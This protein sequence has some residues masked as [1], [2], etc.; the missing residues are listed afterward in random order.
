MGVPAMIEEPAAGKVAPVPIPVTV[1]A[2]F[3]GAGKTTLVNHIL[4]GNHGQR[5]AVVVN[6]FGSINID[7]EL[8]TNL[9]Q[10]MVSLANGCICCVIRSDLI[11][12]VLTLAG[13]ADRPEH[14]IIESSGV[15]NP[16]S[17]ERAF[18]LPEIWHT[19]QYAGTVSVVD[20]DQVL[21]LTDEQALNGCMPVNQRM[22]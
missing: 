3:L 16:A 18:M 22:E 7:S 4:N 1:V 21:S 19:A 9:G 10:G 5:I 2:G 14:I 6:D 12:A 17:V 15:A 13:E 11:S 8:I 20:A